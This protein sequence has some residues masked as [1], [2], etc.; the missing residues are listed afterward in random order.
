MRRYTD[1]SRGRTLQ[2]LSINHPYLDM[3]SR[4]AALLMLIGGELCP[5][6]VGEKLGMSGQSVYNWV[7]T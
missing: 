6:A 1:K 3:R 4:A 7:H 2:L 5:M